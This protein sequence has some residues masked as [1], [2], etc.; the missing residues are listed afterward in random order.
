MVDY[1]SIL[2]LG[3]GFFAAVLVLLT[4]EP[5][6]SKY[7]TAGAGILALAGGL[8]LYGQGYIAVSGTILEAVLH[9]VFAV[10]RMFVGDSDFGDISEAPLFAQ[11]W[12]VTLC[13]CLHERLYQVI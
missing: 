8:M 4:A 2:V 12:A 11:Q 9:T 13:W 3:C 6:I 5:K 1:I 7:L 10:C